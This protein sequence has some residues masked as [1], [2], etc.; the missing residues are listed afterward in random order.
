MQKPGLIEQLWE[1]EPVITRAF[2]AGALPSHLYPVFVDHRHEISFD[3]AMS[4][5]TK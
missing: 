3:K 1:S 4:E 2:I 5:I